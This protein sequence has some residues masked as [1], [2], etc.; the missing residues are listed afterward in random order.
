MK[1]DKDE[2][3][4]HH[5]KYCANMTFLKSFTILNDDF[6]LYCTNELCHLRKDVFRNRSR[7]KQGLTNLET[8]ALVVKQVYKPYCIYV[9]E[10]GLR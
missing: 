6:H 10:L 8:N 9:E 3:V 1:H 4:N 5:K 7:L 2:F